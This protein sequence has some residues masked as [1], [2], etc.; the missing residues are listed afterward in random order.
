[1]SATTRKETNGTLIYALQKGFDGFSDDE[2]S[3]YNK[4]ILDVL[5]Q[6]KEFKGRQQ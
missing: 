3:K 6:Y 5:K 2:V 4:S 1:M